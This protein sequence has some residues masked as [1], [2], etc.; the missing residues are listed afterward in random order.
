M[1]DHALFVEAVSRF[2]HGL[3]TPHDSLSV[4]EDLTETATSVLG[5]AGSGVLLA[6]DDV[7]TFATAFP[8]PVAALEQVQERDQRGPG[9]DACRSGHVVTV[10]DLALAG[11]QWS[12]YAAEAARRGLLAVAGI[13]LRLGGVRVGALSMYAATPREWLEED[14]AAATALADVATGCLI[15]ASR[16]REKEQL[17]AQLQSA[18]DSRV[19]I[20]QAKGIVAA[21]EGTTIPEAFELLRRYSR[22]H[23]LSLRAVAG[24]VVHRGGFPAE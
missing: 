17:A 6:V 16:L 4:L 3:L 12:G 23:N 10:P 11:E 2:T 1:Y 21:T 9:I 15:S 24:D 5:L 18:L 22:D 20:E 7:L 14:V 13:P 8:E 19:V